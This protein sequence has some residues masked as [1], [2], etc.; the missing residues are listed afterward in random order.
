[1]VRT[2]VGTEPLLDFFCDIWFDLIVEVEES[3]PFIPGGSSIHLSWLRLRAFMK[4]LPTVLSSKPSCCEIVICISFDGRFVSLNIACSVRRWRSVKTSRGFF[5]WFPPLWPLLEAVDD[6]DEAED[7]NCDCW[8]GWCCCCCCCCCCGIII[9]PEG[10][11]GIT[12]VCCSSL[13]LQ[14]AREKNPN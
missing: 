6:A 11:L 7:C 8:C 4:K 9:G 5:G 14:A 13:R 2:E 3:S 1:M 12:E 10:Q